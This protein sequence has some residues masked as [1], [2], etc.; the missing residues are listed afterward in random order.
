LVPWGL[1]EEKQWDSRYF[2]NILLKK[3][4]SIVAAVQRLVG[5]EV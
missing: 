4:K 3:L 2:V 1:G 5:P